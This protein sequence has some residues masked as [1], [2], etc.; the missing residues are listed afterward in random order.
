LKNIYIKIRITTFKPVTYL[1]IIKTILKG[2][3]DHLVI[4]RN[5]NKLLKQLEG[6]QHFTVI[7]LA[8][9]TKVN[10]TPYNY[11]D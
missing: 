11:M 5:C 4:Q 10:I 9:D 2:N 7:K 8:T 6:L 1:H 3:I